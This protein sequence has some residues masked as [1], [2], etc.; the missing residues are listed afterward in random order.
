MRALRKFTRLDGGERPPDSPRHRH[1]RADS[2][3][4]RGRLD[5]GPPRHDACEAGAYGAAADAGSRGF[6]R[7]SGDKRRRGFD[8][9][10]DGL[11]REGEHHPQYGAARL[12]RHPLPARHARRYGAG[13]RR[14]R[15]AAE[16]R[17][18]RPVCA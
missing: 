8:R 11:R 10:C 9:R 15:R 2:E 1:S 18:G 14:G 6:V 4:P 13:Q 17:P 3:N 7:Q 12:P 16:Q 5:D